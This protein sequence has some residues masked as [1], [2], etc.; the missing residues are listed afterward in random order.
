MYTFFARSPPSPLNRTVS[1]P[2]EKEL[3]FTGEITLCGNTATNDDRFRVVASLFLLPM[4]TGANQPPLSWAQTF[5]SAPPL[6][7]TGLVQILEQGTSRGCLLQRESLL[8][9][10]DECVGEEIQGDGIPQALLR[11]F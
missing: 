9:A 10:E 1:I 6:T 8:A 11:P 2:I 3:S 4:V 7:N 5:W